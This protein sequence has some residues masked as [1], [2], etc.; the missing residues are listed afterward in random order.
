MLCSVTGGISSVCRLE[1]ASAGLM[2]GTVTPCVLIGSADGSGITS[3]G[4]AASDTV[5]EA[6]ATL[7]WVSPS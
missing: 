7:L 3:L 4:L 5:E 2:G 1:E 6:E